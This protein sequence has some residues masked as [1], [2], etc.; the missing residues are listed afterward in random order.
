MINMGGPERLDQVGNFLLNIMTD[1]DIIQ[2]P[3]AQK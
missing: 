2:F 3:V 1:T